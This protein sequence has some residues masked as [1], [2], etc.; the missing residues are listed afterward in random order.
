M[1][2]QFVDIFELESAA[3]V[4]SEVE[5][6][7]LKDQKPPLN[8]VVEIS[9]QEILVKTG[10]DGDIQ[11]S[12]PFDGKAYDLDLLNR[13]LIELKVKNIDEKTAIFRP[14]QNISY[15]TI[16][17]VMDAVRK[18]D[19]SH[20]PLTGQSVNGVVKTTRKLF[21]NITFETIM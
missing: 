18:V 20:P 19:Q 11:K 8:L 3:P 17:Q 12:I 4:V 16:I 14:Q 2:A 15:K 6:N 7:D 13:T 5:E 1:S 10:L 9:K 21:D